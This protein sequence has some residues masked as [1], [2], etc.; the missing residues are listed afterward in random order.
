MT[1]AAF[2]PPPPAMLSPQQ[3][4]DATAR[5]SRRTNLRF[6]VTVGRQSLQVAVAAGSSATD[7][8][9][10]VEAI[11]VHA[12]AARTTEPVADCTILRGQMWAD[13]VEERG[14]VLRK[15]SMAGKLS[16]HQKVK[17]SV[18]LAD[19]IHGMEYAGDAAEA[20]AWEEASTSPHAKLPVRSWM[21]VAALLDHSE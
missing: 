6:F 13:A 14:T 1:T 11:Q 10:I 17:L 15:R 12:L 21:P 19:A 2:V 7:V 18:H 16:C 4:T 9:A 5:M 8:L 3:R 20:Q